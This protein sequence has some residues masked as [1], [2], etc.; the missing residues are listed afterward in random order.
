MECQDPAGT[1]LADVV[2][3]LQIR[4]RLALGSQAYQFFPRTSFRIRLSSVSSPT[5]R[6][7][8]AFSRSNVRRRFASETSSVASSFWV[9]LPKSR[10]TRSTPVRM[11]KRFAESDAASIEAA[12]EKAPDGVDVQADLQGSVDYKKHLLKVFAKRAIEAA[13][14]K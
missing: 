13:A 3:L 7:S 5:R 4:C 8:A 14:R 10:E 2:R 11:M 9:G 12:A 6:F 1:S